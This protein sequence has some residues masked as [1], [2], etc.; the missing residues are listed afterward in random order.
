VRVMTRLLRRAERP[1]GA[2]T[3]RWRDRRRLAKKRARAIEY[4]R[5]QDK[6]HQLYRE[7]IAAAQATEGELQ[8]AAKGL[9][10][11]AGTVA[12]RWRTQADHYLPL[13]PE[14]A[15]GPQRR[16]GAGQREAG[17]PVRAACRHHRQRRP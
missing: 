7:L 16:G 11:F 15:P 5:G 1:P 14:R 12:E 6:K 9:A 8:A 4:S 17:Q 13:I 2:P 10:E 3:V